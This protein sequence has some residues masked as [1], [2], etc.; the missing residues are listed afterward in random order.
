M[1]VSDLARDYGSKRPMV[2]EWLEL[3]LD[4]LSFVA[5]DLTAIDL[6]VEVMVIGTLYVDRN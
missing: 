5:S 2:E 4:V 1:T 6:V 3:E